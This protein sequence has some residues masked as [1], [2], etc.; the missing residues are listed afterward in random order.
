[1]KAL[2]SVTKQQQKNSETTSERV[3][4]LE[5]IEH[6]KTKQKMKCP[7]CDFTTGS[8]QGLKN[9]KTRKNKA[10]NNKEDAGDFTRQCDLCETEIDDY[11]DMKMHMKY[12]SYKQVEYE[13]EECDYCAENEPS[14]EVH[15][16]RA[17]SESFE[18]GLCEFV[19]GDLEK[20]E[21]HLFTCEIYECHG[22]EI[23]YKTLSEVKHHV[24][25]EHQKGQQFIQI[26]HAK[27]NRKNKEE[28]DCTKYFNHELFPNY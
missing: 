5:L 26:I 14:M 12:H 20:L 13:C 11:N 25:E 22:C 8:A 23:R 27:P 18:C 16:G 7:D 9:H 24:C 1:M 19:A 28:I 17:H 6:T 15:I 10:T 2:E 4:K 3:H 21:T